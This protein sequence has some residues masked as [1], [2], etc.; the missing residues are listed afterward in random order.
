MRV[1]FQHELFALTNTV[2]L[3][4]IVG[5]LNQSL[6][7]YLFSIASSAQ[8]PF[9]VESVQTFINGERKCCWKYYAFRS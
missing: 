9:L 5:M 1:L 8:L 7:L 4:T 2:P 3:A 6:F